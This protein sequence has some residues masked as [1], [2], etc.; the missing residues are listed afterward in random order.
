MCVAA[1]RRE[2][3]RRRG[4]DETR[5]RGDDETSA[6]TRRD[7]ETTSAAETRAAARAMGG[8]RASSFAVAARGRSG[9]VVHHRVSA[10]DAFPLVAPR[11]LQ[12]EAAADAWESISEN[13][14]DMVNCLTEVRRRDAGFFYVCGARGSASVCAATLGRCRTRRLRRSHLASPRRARAGRRRVDRPGGG[15]EREL[16]SHRSHTSSCLS[17]AADDTTPAVFFWFTGSLIASPGWIGARARLRRAVICLSRSIRR[18]GSRCWMRSSTS[19]SPP[20]PRP[21]ASDRRSPISRRVGLSPHSPRGRPSQEIGAWLAGG[22]GRRGRS[23]QM[24]ALVGGR[25]MGRD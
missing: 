17:P 22:R 25:W 5:R 7:D 15:G 3:Q 18:N 23:A 8:A 10:P 11:N 20:P 24:R 4:D 6:E 1:A 2:R 21:T 14:R 12:G 19:G 16:A 13:A 9:P